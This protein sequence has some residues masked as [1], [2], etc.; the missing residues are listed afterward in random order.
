MAFIFSLIAGFGAFFFGQ[1]FFRRVPPHPVIDSL[2][3]GRAHYL[4]IG[5]L[6][7]MFFPQT[8][9]LVHPFELVR[10]NCIGVILLWIGL[11]TGLSAD[12]QHLRNRGIAAIN[13]QAS[14]VLA[15]GGFAVLAALASGA[16]LYRHLG[17][18]QNRPLAIVL[19]TSFALTARFPA[20]F[21][22]WRDRPLPNR[23]PGQNLPLSNIA[24]IA[25]LCIAFPLLAENPTFYFPSLPFIGAVG[26]T[27]LMIGLGV[28]GGIALDFS[29]RSHRT[30][31]RAL[32]LVMGIV[33][34]LFGLSQVPSLPALA[35]GFLAGIW[36]INTS[37]GKREVIEFTARANDVIEPIFFVFIG[38]LIG[39]FGDETFF[40]PPL[41]PL[42]FTMLLVR[43]MGRTI[44]FT[45][46]QTVWQIPQN[47][48]ELFAWSWHP[49]GTLA[50]AVGAQALDLLKFQH[51]TLL[52]GL[53]I[54]VFLSQIILIPPTNSPQSHS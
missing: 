24:A 45:I 38:T 43:G 54:S 17:L 14:V 47:W 37:V 41:F 35:V 4:L 3:T 40:S 2:R 21:F 11:Q 5:V 28:A 23:V 39:E 50:V 27:P 26:L 8:D 32:G 42:A 22:L 1:K 51:H 49:Q 15:T 36:L 48:R 20:P 29:F 10:S 7:G 44:G 30:G 18:L 6:V 31:S 19:I 53:V 46:S 16:T 9:A 13:S 52:T 34:I 33:I 12:L 25:V